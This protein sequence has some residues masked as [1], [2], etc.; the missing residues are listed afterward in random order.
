[1]PPAESAVFFSSWKKMLLHNVNSGMYVLHA[2][3]ALTEIVTVTS[4]SLER[5]VERCPPG[6]SPVAYLLFMSVTHYS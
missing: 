5:H 4:R 3:R 2:P 1:M 6:A